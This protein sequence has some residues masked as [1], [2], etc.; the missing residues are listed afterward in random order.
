MQNVC[1]VVAAI[2][3]MQD[4]WHVILSKNPQ[5]KTGGNVARSWPGCAVLL[6]IQLEFLASQAWKASGLVNYL[7]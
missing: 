4:G 3:P 6:N 7:T 5:S 1:D 2:E